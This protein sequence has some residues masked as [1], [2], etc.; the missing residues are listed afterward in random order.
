MWTEGQ[1]EMTKLIA[2]FRSFANA[3]MHLPSHPVMYNVHAR[4][5]QGMASYESRTPIVPTGSSIS[6][7]NQF[8]AF[9]W[10]YKLINIILY[11]FTFTYKIHS[12]PLVVRV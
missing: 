9:C 12:F 2:D 3:H 1:T 6:N 5:T 10:Q 8:V 4:T 7:L 11:H